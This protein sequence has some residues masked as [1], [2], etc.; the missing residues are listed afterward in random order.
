MV[1]V[2]ARDDAHVV[3][4]QSGPTGGGVLLADN[5]DG[6]APGL[7][8]EAGPDAGL[9]L[10][11]VGGEYVVQKDAGEAPFFNMLPGAF[12]NASMAIDV[13]LVG[14][15]AGQLV[16]LWCRSQREAPFGGYLVILRPE[17]QSIRLGRVDPTGLRLSEWLFSSAINAGNDVNHIEL[18]CAG[19]TISVAV[20]DVAISTL[21]DGAYQSGSF[22]LAVGTQDDAADVRFD[23]L[24]VMQR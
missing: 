7:L 11:Y 13:R 12:D 5:F 1:P 20:N 23:N 10:G 4:L 15:D 24:A 18:T 6:L 3:A 2:V 8:P 16:Q 21:N 17:I 9:R 14:S 22:S 19:S